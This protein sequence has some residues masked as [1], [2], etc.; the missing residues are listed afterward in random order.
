[1]SKINEWHYFRFTT[2]VAVCEEEEIIYLKMQI[3]SL[4][5]KLLLINTRR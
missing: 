1:M 5:L 4:Y 2:A 3:G